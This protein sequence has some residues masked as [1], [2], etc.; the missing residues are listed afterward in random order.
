M[1]W[2]L[3]KAKGAVVSLTTLP[4]PKGTSTDVTKSC[5]SWYLRGPKARE[6][7]AKGPLSPL[8]SHINRPGDYQARP[9]GSPGPLLATRSSASVTSRRASL[10][11]P[12]PP[13]C[14]CTPGKHSLA[15]QIFM[16]AARIH[17]LSQILSHG[18]RHLSSSPVTAARPLAAKKK[19]SMVLPRVA[20]ENPRDHKVSPLWARAPATG[21]EG[22]SAPRVEW[23]VILSSRLKP[24]QATPTY[25]GSHALTCDWLK[26]FK[27][28]V[29]CATSVRSGY[30]KVLRFR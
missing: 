14:S 24:I 27:A 22:S 28:C 21:A 9:L 20:R 12:S 19:T 23:L 13:L 6:A 30:V 29:A 2:G 3:V 7:P 25:S 15:R 10:R 4:E 26:N 17:E 1:R 18:G 16:R 5:T 11:L 8:C